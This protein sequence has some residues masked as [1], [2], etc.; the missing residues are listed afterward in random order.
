[1]SRSTSSTPVPGRSGT[2]FIAIT[3]AVV[4]ALT[5]CGRGAPPLDFGRPGPDPE[6]GSVSGVRIAPGDDVADIVAS[7]PPGTTFVF[8]PGVHRLADRIEPRDG[9]RFVGEFGAVLTGA[10]VLTDFALEGSVWVAEGQEQRN[11]PHGECRDEAPR[12]DHPEDLFLDD[13]P[14]FHAA[15]KVEVGPGSWHFDYDNDRI[16]VG[17]D[18]TGR[19]V[20]TSVADAAF[21]GDA[22]DVTIENLVVEKFATRAQTG[23]I[24][25]YRH[26]GVGERWVIRRNEVRLS[27]GVGINAG[28]GA[29]VSANY[30]HHNGQLG[31]SSTGGSGTVFEG[32]EIAH[33][34]YAGF[35]NSWEAGGSKFDQTSG[36][37][38]RQNHV[39]HND[40]PGLW[41]DID[42]IDTLYEYN[43][44]ESNV[45][46]GI[47]HEISFDAVI[48]HNVVVGNGYGRGFERYCYVHCAGILVYSSPNVTVYGNT[49]I[50]N[51]NGITGRY[52]ERGVGAHGPYLLVNLYVHDNLVEMR[53]HEDGIGPSGELGVYG[54]SGVAA[55]ADDPA[56]VAAA[57]NRFDRNEYYVER[58]THFAWLGR[59]LTFE[60]WRDCGGD[61]GPWPGCR[62]DAAGKVQPG[63]APAQS[64][65]SG[66]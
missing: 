37:I 18:P 23:A 45:H 53:Y 22:D 60:E 13:V 38:V 12:C 40:G 59:N 36:L 55:G 64:T 43:L 52:E 7:H 63:R 25:A 57:N 26:G 15:S 11:D 61:E 47:F 48:R 20:E 28:Y 54:V 10:R 17:D 5:A 39:H 42:N 2:A 65:P 56:F 58:D 19:V 33:N 4:L 31:V 24:H 27:H 50:G 8:E 44:V 51:W 29:T 30:V 16:Y 46:T 21:Y 41:T 34:N 14:L 32:N 35:N 6:S 1:M 66:P 62:Q 9:D 3:A 49:V